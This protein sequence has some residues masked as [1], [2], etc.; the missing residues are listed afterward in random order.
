MNNLPTI[1]TNDTLPAKRGNEN[2]IVSLAS[3]STP[4][5]VVRQEAAESSIMDVISAAYYACG[6]KPNAETLYADTKSLR[7]KIAND[8][9]SLS[10]SEVKDAIIGGVM[11][12]RSDYVELSLRRYVTWL[13]DYMQSPK[14]KMVAEKRREILKGNA[15][16]LPEVSETE[17]AARCKSLC[18]SAFNDYRAKDRHFALI[19]KTV[20]Y[21][22]LREKG[23][24]R[25]TPDRKRDIMNRA[26][27]ALLKEYEE[28]KNKAV[29]LSEISQLKNDVA[30]LMKVAQRPN[31][32]VVAKC[33]ELALLEYFDGLIEIGSDLE[34][35]FESLN[36]YCDEA[37]NR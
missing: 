28:R 4:L 13:E 25:L 15:A 27:T 32:A 9:R 14:R 18:I 20:V 23:L 29:A 1:P 16:L 37:N 10:L 12:T 17:K 31:N 36:N 24:L 22:I 5:A 30:E 19:P 35:E 6:R 33:K 21:D 34:E 2:P 8:F 26:K 3:D 11:S 7:A